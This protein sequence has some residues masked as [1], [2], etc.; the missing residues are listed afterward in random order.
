[1]YTAR[2]LRILYLAWVQML[3]TLQ[4]QFDL[5]KVYWFLQIAR[6]KMHLRKVIECC[7]KL[8]KSAVSILQGGESSGSLR[9][10]DTGEQISV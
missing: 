10:L 6:M 8:K 4:V 5:V 2:S 7:F 3:R 1:M 9:C